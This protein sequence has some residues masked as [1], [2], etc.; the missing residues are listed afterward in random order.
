VNVN[1]TGTI[2]HV[3]NAWRAVVLTAVIRGSHGAPLLAATGA[4]EP[5]RADHAGVY[6]VRPADDLSSVFVEARFPPGVGALR[7]RDGDARR[8]QGLTGCKDEE[9]GRRNDRI[10]ADAADGCLKYQYP[11][12]PRSGR[13]SPPVAAGVIVTAPS[14]WLFTPQLDDGST[15]RIELSLPTAVEASVPWRRLGPDTYELGR[16]PGSSTGSAI[17][18]AIEVVE[19]PL[20][21][22]RLDVALVDGPGHELDRNKMLDWLRIAA[23]DVSGV[24]GVFPNP[25][26]QVIVQ[27][28]TSRSRSP[29][30]FGYVIRDGGEA[31][32]FFVDP[33]RPLDDYLADW[34]A[35]HEFS[36]LLL[37]YVRGS[38]K[39]VSEGFASY[40]QNV[41]LAR[42]GAYSETE[43]WNRLDRSFEQAAGIRNPPRL[44][45]LS[46]RP[47]WEVRMLIYWSGAAMALMAD[48]RL[49]ELTEGRQSLDS[50]L[51]RLA[52]CCL[53]SGRVWRAEELFAKLDDLSPHPV[54]LDLYRSL[55]D[56]PGM[57]DLDPLYHDLGVVR[58]DGGIELVDGRR[59]ADV[60][61]AIMGSDTI[62]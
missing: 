47:F 7:A 9:L 6:R 33:H 25:A 20:E 4:M 16:S 40:Y 5:A 43:V 21:G 46:E 22:G 59:L 30:P 45:A 11:L 61:K 26:V 38:E 3:R 62:R 52:E 29:V 51:A 57:P 28:V 50:V 34:T 58:N 54:F 17:F 8:L 42:R 24:G 13:R 55:S 15:I 19:L 56:S 35:T 53:P 60:R 23:G 27:P 37:P 18:G 36:H 48:T 41:L 10:L 39:W 44:S 12:R 49:R 1:R 2:R 31:V 14:E 32:R